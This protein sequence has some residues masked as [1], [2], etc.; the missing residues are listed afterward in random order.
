MMTPGGTG[1][2]MYMMGAADS[3]RWFTFHI[4]LAL[5][6]LWATYIVRSIQVR[7]LSGPVLEGELFVFASTVSA[8]ALGTALFER[9]VQSTGIMVSCCALLFVLL[10]SSGL[11]FATV[12]ARF[13]ENGAIHPRR[14]AILSLLCAVAASSFGYAVQAARSIR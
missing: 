13:G 6:P 7:P 10:V 12:Q 4:A 11:F 9:N 8:S 1:S 2:T 3:F 14:T 5:F